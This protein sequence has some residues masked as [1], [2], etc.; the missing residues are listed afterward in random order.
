M[1]DRLFDWPTLWRHIL[2]G[3]VP[4][5]GSVALYEKLLGEGSLGATILI[6]AA[7]LPLIALGWL[8]WQHWRHRDGPS[9]GG[10][11]TVNPES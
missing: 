6:L 7:I 8:G 1:K 10:Q 11:P 2:L 5:L 3:A 9:A 4:F